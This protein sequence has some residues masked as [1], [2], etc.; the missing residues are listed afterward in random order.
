MALPAAWLAAICLP[1]A[2]RTVTVNIATGNAPAFF[3]AV[4]NLAAGDSVLWVTKPQT[5]PFS[6]T[7]QSPVPVALAAPWPAEPG[8]FQFSHPAN[9][10]LSHLI[11][12]S[13][14]LRTTNWL[15][16]ATHVA[17][18]SSASFSD[19]NAGTNPQFHRAGRLPNP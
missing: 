3:P 5:A 2:A 11:Q 18:A 7:N 19:P 15:T 10:G 17:V 1:G 9:V 8:S 4:T 13:T 6:F 16:I 14:N 12:V